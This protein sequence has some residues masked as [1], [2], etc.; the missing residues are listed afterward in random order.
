VYNKRDP[1]KYEVL[2]CKI[3]ITNK[4]K[5]LFEGEENILFLLQTLMYKHTA[6]IKDE[7]KDLMILGTEIKKKNF[8]QFYIRSI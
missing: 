5:Q 2:K 6:V 8:K 7:M 4:A 1:G 3:R